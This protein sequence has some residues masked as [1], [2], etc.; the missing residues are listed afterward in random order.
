MC[1][2]PAFGRQFFDN[3]RETRGSASFEHNRHQTGI[4]LVITPA[5]S[6]GKAFTEPI[7]RAGLDAH[8]ENH[9]A[10]FSPENE[11]AKQ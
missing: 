11:Q 9:G 5:N 8:R 10:A 1:V 4:F 2:G 6:G 7:V 3:L